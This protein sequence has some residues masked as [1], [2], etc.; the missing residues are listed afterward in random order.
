MDT[1]GVISTQSVL[2]REEISSYEINLLAS[3]MDPIN[4]RQTVTL[5]IISVGDVND[6]NPFFTPLV[7]SVS[8]IESVSLPHQLITVFASDNDIGTNADVSFSLVVS[9]NIGNHFDIASDTGRCCCCCCCC[10]VYVLTDT[11]V[12]QKWHTLDQLDSCLLPI[13]YTL[14]LFF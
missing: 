13:M 7:L 14:I 6:Q 5:L 8:V 4:P 12:A 10:L 3:D 9:S 2:D 1:G 11:I